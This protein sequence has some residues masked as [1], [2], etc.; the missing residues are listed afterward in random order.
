[1]R[2]AQSQAVLRTVKVRR[3]LNDGTARE[4]RKAAGLSLQDVADAIGVD[5]ASV[6]RW[7]TRRRTPRR[8]LALRYADLLDA[9]DRQRVLS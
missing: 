7:E 8:D 2:E 5:I 9:L 3:M 4:R 1:M 6:Y